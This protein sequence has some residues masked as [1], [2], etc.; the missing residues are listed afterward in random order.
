[1]LRS[2]KSGEAPE[3]QENGMILIGID[4]GTTCCKSMIND[5]SGRILAQ[6]QDEYDIIKES[7]RIEQ[8]AGLA[9]KRALK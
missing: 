9:S 8:D 6:S 2:M 4:L 7:D 3:M 1:M 5:E